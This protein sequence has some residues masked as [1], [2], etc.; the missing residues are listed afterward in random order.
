MHPSDM[1]ELR[2]L[3]VGDGTTLAQD[4]RLVLGRRSGIRVLEPV[5]EVKAALSAASSGRVDLVVVHL[6]R[7]PDGLGT[8]TGLRDGAPRIRVL[9][10]GLETDA[11]TA[12]A[13]LAA[14]GCG[15]LPRTYEAE[16]LADAFR[17]AIRGEVVLPDGPW[18][19]L[20][21]MPLTGPERPVVD[22][23]GSLT[24]REI[25]VLELLAAGRSTHEIAS[26]LGISATTVQSHVKNLLAKLG[27]HS[28]VEAVRLAWRSGAVATPV[29]A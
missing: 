5:S 14:G 8:V 23:L 25:E 28:K 27:V 9:A 18:P 3:V 12:A 15:L 29:G 10:A 6:D 2:V 13:V 1:G 22:L 11:D 24:P 7:D 4:L 21:R 26:S 17:R 20:G 16:V 19:V